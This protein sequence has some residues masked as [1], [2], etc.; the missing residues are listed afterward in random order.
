MEKNN[1]KTV[2]TFYIKSKFFEKSI[3]SFFLKIPK[4]LN[5]PEYYEFNP[6]KKSNLSVDRFVKECPERGMRSIY[7]MWGETGCAFSFYHAVSGNMV[8]SLNR[9]GNYLQTQVGSVGG[10]VFLD[11]RQYVQVVLNLCEDVAILNVKIEENE[12]IDPLLP[13]ESDANSIRVYL[14]CSYPAWTT[15]LTMII[16]K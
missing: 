1:N 14:G 10:V 13:W 8:V 16:G 6:E 7:I 4:V 3:E 9:F 12:D 2:V 11:I 15:V 5:N